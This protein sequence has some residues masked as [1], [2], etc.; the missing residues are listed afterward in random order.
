MLFI[1]AFATLSLV[2]Y[3][4]ELDA[5]SSV[6]DQESDQDTALI[7]WLKTTSEAN[8]A[9]LEKIQLLV[10]NVIAK[11]SSLEKKVNEWENVRTKLEGMAIEKPETNA[12]QPIEAIKGPE[13]VLAVQTPD[14]AIY[15]MV[16]PLGAKDD[17]QAMDDLAKLESVDKDASENV[18]NSEAADKTEAKSKKSKIDQKQDKKRSKRATKGKSPHK[19]SKKSPKQQ[20]QSKNSGEKKSKGKK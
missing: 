11:V 5:P 2:S 14:Q 17:A 15:K 6:T 8:I 18:E 4:N 3:S 7:L 10:E 12:E 9:V 20:Y 1:A 13:T 16:E 19:S